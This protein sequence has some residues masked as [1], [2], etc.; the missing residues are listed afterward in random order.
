MESKPAKC[1]D[2]IKFPRCDIQISLL[3]DD[4]LSQSNSDDSSLEG[5]NGNH[6][7]IQ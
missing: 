7:S 1:E 4:E 2:S 3:E 6:S 5:G